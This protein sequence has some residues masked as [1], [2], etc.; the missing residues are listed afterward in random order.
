MMMCRRADC[1]F[2]RV[3]FYSASLVS[4][5]R[6]AVSF[7]LHGLLRPPRTDSPSH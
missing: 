2:V 7:L 5:R 4:R 1:S 6:E 3:T